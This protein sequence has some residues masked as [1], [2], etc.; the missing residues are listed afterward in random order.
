MAIQRSTLKTGPAIVTFDGATVFFKNGL[1]LQE[2]IETFDILVDNFGKVDTRI[3]DRKVTISGIPAGEWEN[4]TVLFPWLGVLIGTRAHGDADRALIIHAID[5]TKYTY[6]NATLTTMPNLKF[7]ATETLLG[8]VEWTARVKDNTE[9]T[10]AN[11]LFTRETAS[12]TD[13]SFLTANV[14]TQPYVLSWGTTPWDSFATVD[15]IEVSFDTKWQDLMVDGYGVL[16]Q[17][18]EDIQVS[19]KFKPLGIAQSDIDAK[20]AL[21]N[22]AGAALG[23]S[24]AARGADLAIYGTGVYVL[25]RGAAA[26]SMTQEFGMGKLRNGEM[27]VVATRT[28]VDGVAQPLAVVDISD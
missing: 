21:Q 14:K 12:F 22:D 25:V 4:L 1:K 27:D 3:K 11:S 7:S 15:G 2:T 9:P 24:L 10:A 18:L 8:N 20:L 5:G 19:A 16:D 28:F 23:S 17:I 26:K 13:A 6:H